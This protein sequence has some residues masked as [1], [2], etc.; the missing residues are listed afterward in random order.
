MAND[1]TH[2]ATLEAEVRRIANSCDLGGLN[3][4]FFLKSTFT[5]DIA[6]LIQR[7]ETA[8]FQRGLVATNNK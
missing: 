5:S 2:H 8:A 4:E 6:A 1:Q 7:C 3:T